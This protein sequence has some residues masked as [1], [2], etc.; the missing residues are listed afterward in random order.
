MVHLGEQ[1]LR[2]IPRRPDFLLRLAEGYF[3]L[4]QVATRAVRKLD[5]PIYDACN[6]RKNAGDCNKLRKAQKGAEDTLNTTREQNIKTLA[7][8]VKRDGAQLGEVFMRGYV[9]M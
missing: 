5:D 2:A 8:L 7:L 6:K 4:V 9:V 3:E 1:N